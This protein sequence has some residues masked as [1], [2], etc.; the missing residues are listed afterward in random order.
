MGKG[1]SK[2]SK[3]DL[4]QLTK[5]SKFTGEELKDLYH[6]FIKQNPSGKMDF[7]HWLHSPANPVAGD[8]ALSQRWFKIYDRDGSGYVDF[9]E[10]ATLLSCLVRGTTEERLEIV[11][12]FYDV[13]GDGNIT[14]EELKEVISSIFYGAKAAGNRH[15]DGVS[16][17]DDYVEQFFQIVDEN[18]DGNVS[19][20][21]FVSV[22]KEADKFTLINFL[23]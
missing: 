16:T 22:A 1:N 5:E 13:N 17:V 12:S 23:L 14:K 6:G 20:D 3:E 7:E 2:L 18:K 19:R 9:R 4:D 21:E 8:E 15:L 10:L 11:F